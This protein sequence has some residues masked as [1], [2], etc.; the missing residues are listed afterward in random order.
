MFAE[1]ITIYCYV[2][3]TTLSDGLTSIFSFVLKVIKSSTWNRCYDI[4][5]IQIVTDFGQ[6]LNSANGLV[7]VFAIPRDYEKL[8][9]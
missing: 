2:I 8:Y 4:L 5:N 1:I 6:F 9:T 3:V 7:N